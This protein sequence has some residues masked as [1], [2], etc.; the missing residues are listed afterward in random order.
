MERP[1]FFDLRDRQRGVDAEARTCDPVIKSHRVTPTGLS[2]TI[3][4]PAVEFKVRP[5]RF[6]PGEHSISII[7][8]NT[9]VDAR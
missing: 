5:H 8:R 4:W 1:R 3:L 7:M 6:L 2:R 9:H